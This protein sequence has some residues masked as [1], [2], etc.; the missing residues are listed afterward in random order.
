MCDG[1][2]REER[3]KE[4]T[5]RQEANVVTNS[6]HAAVFACIES[7]LPPA[8]RLKRDIVGIII[9]ELGSKSQSA[10]RACRARKPDTPAIDDEKVKRQ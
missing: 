4:M 2:N 3:E 9:A 5:K 6:F 7:P 10:Q 1:G 8:T